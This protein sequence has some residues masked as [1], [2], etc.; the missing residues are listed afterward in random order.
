M[1]RSGRESTRLKEGVANRAFAFQGKESGE[2]GKLAD[3]ETK[4]KERG[5]E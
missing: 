1:I 3:G 4:K 5:E 2:S